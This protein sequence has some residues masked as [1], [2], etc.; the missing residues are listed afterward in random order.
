MGKGQ[1]T[2]ATLQASGLTC[3]LCAKAIF[4]NLTALKFV[5]NVDTDLNT[6]TFL[7][8]FKPG[9]EIS[10]DQIK[11]KVEAAGFSVSNLILTFTAN[12]QTVSQQSPLKI[13]ITYFHFIQSKSNVLSGTVKMQIIDKGYVG[14][15]VFKK[16]LAGNKL[17]CYQ[18]L[19]IADC[20][21]TENITSSTTYHVII[22]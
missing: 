10:P 5:N 9:N 6:S 22:K 2:S 21:N 19:E 15:K 20:P 14:T 4:T 8:S 17:A 16:L 1:F 11:S 13:G 18:S 3:A 12:G 7:I